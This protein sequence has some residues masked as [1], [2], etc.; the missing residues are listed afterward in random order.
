MAWLWRYVLRE[1]GWIKRSF[2]IYGTNER[3]IKLTKIVLI[4]S[5]L[6]W[7]VH[8]IKL[9]QNK[10]VY[11]GELDIDETENEIDNMFVDLE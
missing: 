3:K 5:E 10:V 6:A 4:Q 7:I 11:H 8:G 1:N 2:P 9:T